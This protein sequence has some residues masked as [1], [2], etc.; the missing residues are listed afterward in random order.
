MSPIARRIDEEKK[1]KK[2]PPEIP[3]LYTARIISRGTLEVAALRRDGIT[4]ASPSVYDQPYWYSLGK[5]ES[6]TSKPFSEPRNSFLRTPE[7]ASL[8]KSHTRTSFAHTFEWLVVISRN[9]GIVAKLVRIESND[10]AAS[11]LM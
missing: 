10:C 5:I 1:K 11:G 4:E 8:P 7:V 6:T 2:R 9:Y 3:I